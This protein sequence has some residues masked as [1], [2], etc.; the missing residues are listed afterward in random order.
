MS[1]ANNGKS[2]QIK[3]LQIMRGVVLGQRL[4]KRV[5][6][7]QINPN[8]IYISVPTFCPREGGSS[9]GHLIIE[10]STGRVVARFDEGRLVFC[11]IPNSV[12]DGATLRINGI[13]YESYCSVSDK[14]RLSYVKVSDKKK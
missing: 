5:V 4:G 12:W 11:K 8:D 6:Q 10:K 3:E 14:S 9:G 7:Q 1:L 13:V 2:K